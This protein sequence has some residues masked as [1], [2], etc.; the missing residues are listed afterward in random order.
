MEDPALA[1]R[2]GKWNEERLR[3]HPE[4]FAAEISAR[5][6]NRA[7]HFF[8][9]CQ[10]EGAEYFPKITKA[11]CQV[12]VGFLDVKFPAWDARMD[13]AAKDYFFP[14]I[15]EKFPQV[16]DR[17]WRDRFH[18]AEASNAA[19][20]PARRQVRQAHSRNSQEDSVSARGGHPG[21][22]RG[23]GDSRR[24]LSR[25]ATAFTLAGKTFR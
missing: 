23:R 13:T 11:H 16:I 3:L 15:A 12:L 14:A 25:P 5:R 10:T 6:E 22:G 8:D 9:I 7:N 4:L 1:A 24:A 2:V 17:Q 20:E 21:V 18:Y 19:P